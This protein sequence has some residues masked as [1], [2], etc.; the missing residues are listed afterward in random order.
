[1]TSASC[2]SCQSVIVVDMNRTSSIPK[3]YYTFD[4]N[5]RFRDSNNLGVKPERRR[6]SVVASAAGAG[7]GAEVTNPF[8]VSIGLDSQVR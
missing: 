3:P 8:S 5:H 4:I 7:A 2:C 1:M 6:I